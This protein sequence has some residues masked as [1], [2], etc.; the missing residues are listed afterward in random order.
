VRIPTEA[1]TL[2]A[3][4]DSGFGGGTRYVHTNGTVAGWVVGAGRRRP[5]LWRAG[6]PARLP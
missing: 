4:P 6:A 2:T 1:Y 3:L 5:A